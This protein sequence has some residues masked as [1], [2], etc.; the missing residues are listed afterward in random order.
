VV[1]GHMTDPPSFLKYSS[2]V[3]RDSVW[4]GFWL[5]VLSDIDLI[6]VDIGKAYLQANTREWV[7]TGP[8]FGEVQ[9][10]NAIIVW[11]SMF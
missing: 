1:G 10:R 9:G 5:A 8:E 6:T 11:D 3:S 7:Y 2:I 4:L